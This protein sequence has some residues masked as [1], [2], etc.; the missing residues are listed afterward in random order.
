M[1]IWP[2]WEGTDI[3]VKL[4]GCGP[5]LWVVLL[6]V[7]WVWNVSNITS[8][9]ALYDVKKS[10]LYSMRS[11]N[12]PT[13]YSNTPPKMGYLRCDSRAIYVL[14]PIHGV[15]TRGKKIRLN[16][17]TSFLYKKNWYDLRYNL[18]YIKSYIKSCKNP[19]GKSN[20]PRF[21]LHDLRYDFEVRF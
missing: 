15:G 12:S 1:K 16:E 20:F 6:Q 5:G 9:N 19:L 21:F 18:S 8:K 3:M 10:I 2:L 17:K 7:S 13:F 14:V 11:L 4:V